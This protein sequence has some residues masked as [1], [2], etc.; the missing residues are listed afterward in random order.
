[1]FFYLFY[2]LF[3]PIIFLSIHC[4]KFFN[5]K[6]YIHL[7]NER[8]TIFDA[9]SKIAKIDRYK[10]KVLLF[11]AASAGEFAQLKPILKNINRE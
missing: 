3:S 7:K 10:K 9:I 2:F 1:M 11:H 4:I 8:A 5:K 6:L